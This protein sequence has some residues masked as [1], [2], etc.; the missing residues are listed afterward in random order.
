MVLPPF[1]LLGL[2]GR[3]LQ[4]NGV[5][6]REVIASLASG[7][8]GGLALA[9]VGEIV[10]LLVLV[11]VGALVMAFTPDGV[12]RFRQWSLVLQELAQQAD[13]ADLLEW[14][15]SSPLIIV[16]ALMLVAIVVPLVEETFK[17]LIV[18]LAGRW[19]RPHPAQ[20]LL[21]GVASGAGFA[22]SENL[23]NGALGA[24]DA[25]VF[26]ALARVGA[27]VMHCC[28][29]ALVGWGWGQL[30]TGRRPGR[31]VACYLAAV[32]LHGVWNAAAACSA[33]A[34]LTAIRQEG[35]TAVSGLAGAAIVLLLALLVL[36]GV[37]LLVGLLVATRFL[38]RQHVAEQ[39]QA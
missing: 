37:A 26:G 9:L 29:A 11:L 23:L 1:V 25:W 36:L 19:V 3:S 10:A 4:R 24:M 18:G 33:F 20:A 7:G 38:A 15:S 2:V 13:L 16:G 30:W 34:G 8:L 17:T 6:W 28:T 35:N 22:A 27:T 31:L 14:L 12:D 32:A 5:T 21:W 39:G